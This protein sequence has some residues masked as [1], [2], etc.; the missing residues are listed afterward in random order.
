MRRDLSP[1]RYVLALR[2]TAQFFT[3][4]LTRPTFGDLKVACTYTS[5]RNAARD[6]EM[7]RTLAGVSTE[8]LD[9][10]TAQRRA[11]LSQR[12]ATPS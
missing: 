2:S 3:L 12:V 9:E 5:A 1:R 6:A 7:L 8:V 4:D 11:L 10:Q